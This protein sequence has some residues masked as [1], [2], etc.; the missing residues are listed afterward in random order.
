MD[1]TPISELESRQRKHG[2]QGKCMVCN[3]DNLVKYRQAVIGK[4]MLWVC[5]RCTNLYHIHIICGM[6]P[7][8]TRGLLRKQREACYLCKRKVIVIDDYHKRSH[9]L[10]PFPRRKD[11]GYL[12]CRRC[13][14]MANMTVGVIG[15]KETLTLIEV[16][17]GVSAVPTQKEGCSG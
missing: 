8:R 4:G 16:M 10:S 2:K 15:E 14:T 12:L 5:T 13:A 9:F 3:Q 11:A 17:K 1:N 6:P 7:T